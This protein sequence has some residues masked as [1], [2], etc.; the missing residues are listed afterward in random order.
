MKLA[1]K[2]SGRDSCFS[3][4]FLFEKPQIGLKEWTE[5]SG[6]KRILLRGTFFN[7]SKYCINFFFIVI[8]KILIVLFKLI[9]FKCGTKWLS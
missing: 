5:L 1:A 3:E 8:K 6:Q 9:S 2:I 7:S 4:P